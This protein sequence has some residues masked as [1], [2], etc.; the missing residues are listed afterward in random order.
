MS[1]DGCS[2]ATR[3]WLALECAFFEPFQKF[4][5]NETPQPT[6]ALSKRVSRNI[7]KTCPTHQGPAVHLDESGGLFRIQDANFAS[8]GIRAWR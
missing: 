8:I 4:V 3:Q 2:Y 5:F 7:A 6:L 1:A